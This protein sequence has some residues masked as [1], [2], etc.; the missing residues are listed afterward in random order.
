MASPGS[1]LTVLKEGLT[2]PVGAA[3]VGCGCCLGRAS[4]GTGTSQDGQKWVKMFTDISLE[5]QVTAQV[6]PRAFLGKKR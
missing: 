3:A 5:P 4:A 2:P 1:A 6:G